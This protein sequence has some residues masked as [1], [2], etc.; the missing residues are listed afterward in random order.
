[1]KFLKL[2]FIALGMMLITQACQKEEPIQITDEAEF[3]DQEVED[4]AVC[5]DYGLY[6]YHVSQTR[7]AFCSDGTWREVL[8]FPS[9][10]VYPRSKNGTWILNGSG[11][12]EVDGLGFLGSTVEF[13]PW[14]FNQYGTVGDQVGPLKKLFRP[15]ISD[16]IPGF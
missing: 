16:V 2:I 7:L 12:V 10:T 4:R 8:V 14:S 13:E 5:Y 6:K 15:T 1:M 11:N 9:G 3:V